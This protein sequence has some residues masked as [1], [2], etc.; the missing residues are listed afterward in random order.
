MPRTPRKTATVRVPLELKSQIERICQIYRA[1]KNRETAQ[2][3]LDK[4][5]SKYCQ[6][7]GE[8]DESI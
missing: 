3:E 8:T 5:L 6:M 2:S 7:A 4:L 1:T